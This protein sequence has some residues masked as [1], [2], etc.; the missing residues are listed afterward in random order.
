VCNQLSPVVTLDMRLK[1]GVLSACTLD[2]RLDGRVPS[3]SYSGA[4]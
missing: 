1:V 4:H 2:M 3:A